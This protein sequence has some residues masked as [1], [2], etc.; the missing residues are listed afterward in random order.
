M[1]AARERTGV[2]FYCRAA[3]IDY[4]QAI[5]LQLPPDSRAVNIGAGLGTTALALLQ[6]RL[7]LLVVSVDWAPC[8]EELAALQVHAPTGWEQRYLRLLQSSP[9]AG[10]AWAFGPV[11]LVLVDGGHYYPECQ[12]DARAWY[13]HLAPDGWLLFHDV[14]AIMLP[15]VAPAVQDFVNEV[16]AIFQDLIDTL[17]AYRKPPAP[18]PPAFTVAC[19]KTTLR[20][21]EERERAGDY[22]TR[23][24]LILEAWRL[25]V[26]L[27]YPAGVRFDQDDPAWPVVLI[28]LP[29][30]QVSWHITQHAQAWDGHGTPEKW[31][32]VQVYCEG[33]HQ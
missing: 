11:D 15:E 27:D 22:L 26:L 30:G 29:T 7:D 21:I 14:N 13:P 17:A 8:P 23:N 18:L 20:Q 32:R 31:R 19:L 6:A 16:G 3:E 33:D 25:A 12:A 10:Q 5:A 2:D 24:Q 28:E 9:A 1:Q 4:L